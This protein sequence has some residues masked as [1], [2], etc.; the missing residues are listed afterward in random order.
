MVNDLCAAG[1]PSRFD[2]LHLPRLQLAPDL[3]IVQHR[4]LRSVRLTWAI[5]EYGVDGG[6]TTV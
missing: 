3:L 5:V 1:N 6:E 2:L 4:S